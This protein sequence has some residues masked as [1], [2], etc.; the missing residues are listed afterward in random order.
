MII[1]QRDIAPETL[2]G[3]HGEVW[4][5]AKAPTTAKYEKSLSGDK[6][7]DLKYGNSK[8]ATL[9]VWS[10]FTRNTPISALSAQFRG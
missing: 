8:T 3:I 6:V 2:E 10:E 9:I 7:A 1:P 5:C 4:C